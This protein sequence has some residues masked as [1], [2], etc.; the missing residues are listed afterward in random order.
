MAVYKFVDASAFFGNIFFC[1]ECC[2]RQQ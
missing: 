2:R 1:T